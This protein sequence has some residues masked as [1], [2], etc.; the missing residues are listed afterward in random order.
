ML[1]EGQTANRPGVSYEVRVKVAAQTTT[2]PN[3]KI[4]MTRSTWSTG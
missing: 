3:Y 2:L 4:L 1:I